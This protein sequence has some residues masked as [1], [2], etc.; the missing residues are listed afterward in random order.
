MKKEGVNFYLNLYKNYGEAVF[1]RFAH[2]NFYFLNSPEFVKA[3]F[4][5]HPEV[6]IKGDQYN[7]LRLAMGNGLLTSEGE[8]WSKQ[9]KLLNP[10]FA[11]EG[12]DFVLPSIL[13]EIDLFVG[14][15]F[16]P[17]KVY[18]LTEMMFDFTL[19]VA[20]AAFFGDSLSKMEKE[21]LSIDCNVVMKFISRRMSRA[22]KMPLWV[23]NKENTE[24]I[25]SREQ[26]LELVKKIYLERVQSKNLAGKDLLQQLIDAKLSLSEVFD[27]TISFIFAGHETTALTLGWLFF[28]LGSHENYQD[29]VYSEFKE[30]KNEISPINM[31]NKA[32][33][34]QAI[35]NET[36]RLYPAG[37]IISR[38]IKED[39]EL[40]GIFLK[41]GRIVAVSPL[42]L[43]RS[44]RYWKRPEE[45]FPERFIEGINDFENVSK[46]VYIPFSVGRRNCIGARFATLE[47][48]FFTLEFFSKFK[49]EIV[50]KNIGLKGFVTLK[51]S[52]HIKAKII[53]RDY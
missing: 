30:L 26:I 44:S 29:K 16:D 20:I 18:D 2:R 38:D 14:S 10:I 48:V 50:D 36:M 7:P 52:H 15:E 42:V 23:P 21:K 12:L 13:K 41:R 28:S 8:E 53:K 1:L 24:F 5:D 17:N 11:K 19:N 25:K 46:Y 33:W 43:H 37:W 49:L 34:S 9:R 27:Q 40:N 3:I 32:N 4:V 35:V 31:F 51:P 45:F 6:F 47:M 22:F 39:I